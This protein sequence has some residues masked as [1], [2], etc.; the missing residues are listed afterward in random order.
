MAIC[1]N[2][3]TDKVHHPVQLVQDVVVN[4]ISMALSKHNDVSKDEDKIS[5]GIADDL[6]LHPTKPNQEEMQVLK[7]ALEEDK[8]LESGSSPS[9]LASLPDKDH[10]MWMND[11]EVD[12]VTIPKEI[13]T[14]T[15]PTGLDPDGIHECEDGMMIISLNVFP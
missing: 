8:S 11:V 12:N 1:W 6:S 14:D 10:V 15:I 2:T 5:S 3:Y 4:D 13:V 7:K 9:K